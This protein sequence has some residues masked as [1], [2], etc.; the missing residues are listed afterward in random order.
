MSRIFLVPFPRTRKRPIV[1]GAF[2][3]V[4]LRSRRR[5]IRHTSVSL[6]LQSRQI[7]VHDMI[8]ASK[9]H[10]LASPKEISRKKGY[11][12]ISGF[13]PFRAAC[14]ADLI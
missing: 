2:R 9:K 10:P 11:I 12:L 6:F 5:L 4:D 3:H 8:D 1:F 7:D 14:L 13:L